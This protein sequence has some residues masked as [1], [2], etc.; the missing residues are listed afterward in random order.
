MRPMTRPFPAAPSLAVL[1]LVLAAAPALA[2]D[3]AAQAPRRIVAGDDD[4]ATPAPRP[5]PTG[6]ASR[7]ASRPRR[8]APA[9]RSKP[10][11]P[12]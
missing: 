11:P 8:A 2:Q 7:P 5:R 4:P 12:R 3:P 1:A 9:T 6:R 10:P